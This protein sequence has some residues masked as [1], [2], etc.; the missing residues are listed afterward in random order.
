MF[1][2]IVGVLPRCRNTLKSAF[3][4]KREGAAQG[5]EVGAR[6]LI[7]SDEARVLLGMLYRIRITKSRASDLT[8][9]IV[10]SSYVEA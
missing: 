9:L 3:G 7:R 1:R 10:F 5:G 2:K 8:E 6:Y 4:P